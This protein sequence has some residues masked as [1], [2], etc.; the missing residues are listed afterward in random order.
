MSVDD[1]KHAAVNAALD[2]L[3]AQGIIGLGTG[4]TVRLFL[5]ALPDAIASGRRIE[6]VPTSE[7]T[8]AE[9]TALGIP[10]LDDDGPWQIAVTFDGADEVDPALDLIKGH[11]GALTRE[12]IVS[13]ASAKTVIMIDDSK[14]SQR[15]GERQSIP[16]E[17]LVFAHKTTSEHLARFG[18]PVRRTQQGQ[19]VRTDGGN[20]IYDLHV[21]PI[22]NARELDAQL[23]GIPGVV[24]TGLFLGRADVVLIG[25][26]RGVERRVRA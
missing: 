25:S 15:L 21:E 16:I 8:R 20:L 10:L 5:Q 12:K 3:P 23:R 18:R 2:D 13:Y 24:E 6:C 26:S 1:H 17:V 4:S 7:Q 22:G 14:L 19:A 9:A 11:G